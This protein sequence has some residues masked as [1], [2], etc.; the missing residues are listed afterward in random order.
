MGFGYKQ[1]KPTFLT[2]EQRGLLEMYANPRSVGKDVWE[3]E[4]NEVKQVCV[5]QDFS[6]FL[7]CL[8]EPARGIQLA[9]LSERVFFFIPR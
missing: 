2:K 1:Q 6:A 8:C 3:T 9:K 7:V 5:F 4:L